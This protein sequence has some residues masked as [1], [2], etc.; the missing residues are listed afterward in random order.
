MS[1]QQNFPIQ[2]GTKLIEDLL[3]P[4]PHELD[5]KAIYE[6]LKATRRFSNHPKALTIH[7]HR[8]LVERMV[9][10]HR[11]YFAE[12][13]DGEGMWKRVMEWA[14]HHDDHEGVIGDIVAP[15][16]NLISA[17]TNVLEI[18]EVKLDRAICAHYGITYPSE[19][20]RGLVHRYDKA[21]ETLEWVHALGN[22]LQ[23]FN[24]FCPDRFMVRGHELTQWARQHQ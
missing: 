17:K 9:R 6:R 18:V 16:K 13:E 22:D 14:Y 4:K 8:H 24:H 20:I 2:I 10:E 3:D 15:V 12:G 23:E 21:A 11:S 1:Y 19:V 7:Q 5:M